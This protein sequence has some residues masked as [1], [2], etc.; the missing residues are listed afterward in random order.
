[1]EN[2]VIG[3]KVKGDQD[4]DSETDWRIKRIIDR[5]WWKNMFK[6]ITAETSKGYKKKTETEQWKTMDKWFHVW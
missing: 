4:S 5:Y 1:M 2:I 6:V 3:K